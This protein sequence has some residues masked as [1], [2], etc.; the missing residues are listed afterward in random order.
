[1][2][3]VALLAA[4]IWFCPLDPLV[5]PQLG[6]GGATDYMALFRPDAPWQAAAAHVGVFK[7][8]PQWAEQA[9]DEQLRAQFADLKRRG[10]ALALEY[11]VITAT[12]ECGR[13]VEGWGGEKLVAVARRIASLG[14]TLR[15]LAMDEPQYWF[16]LYG[17]PNACRWTPERMAANAA[18]NVRALRAAFP[19]VEVGDVEPAGFSDLGYIERYRAGLAAMRK[20]FGFAP[21]FFHVDEAWDPA[22]FPA[23]VVALARMVRGARI[24]FGIIADGDPR[25]ASGAA[26]IASADRHI[27]VAERAVGPL[28][29]VIFQSWHPYP[30]H[31]LPETDSDAF[32]WLIDH[33]FSRD[34][35]GARTP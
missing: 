15:Y 10:I 8:Y 25:D 35:P 32:T 4:L 9:S 27:V 29:H 34:A 28:D 3:F 5:R 26:W 21:A 6:Y 19:A 12:P 13:G 17:G 1:M 11:G 7:I 23:D 33:Y 14:G 16:T 22:T 24:P 30:K 18:V 2:Q 31:V 20:A